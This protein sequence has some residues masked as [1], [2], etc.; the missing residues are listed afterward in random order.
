MQD[1]SAGT[2][3]RKM[4]KVCVCVCVC[5]FRLWMNANTCSKK[6]GKDLISQP[7][8]LCAYTCRDAMTINPFWCVKRG[9][10]EIFKPFLVSGKW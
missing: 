9:R 5:V 2:N 1:E 10:I 3:T 7:P 8:C 4:T 6:N